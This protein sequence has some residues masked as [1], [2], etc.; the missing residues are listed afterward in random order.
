MYSNEMKQQLQALLCQQSQVD[1]QQS[2]GEQALLLL[3][4]CC[5][6]QT[7]CNNSKTDI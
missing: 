3:D 5:G 2:L 1:A 7:V 6:T 4:S